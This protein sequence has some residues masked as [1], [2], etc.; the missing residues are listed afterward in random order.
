MNSSI[1]KIYND[2]QEKVINYSDTI[3]LADG[4]YVVSRGDGWILSR[5]NQILGGSVISNGST[6]IVG[7]LRVNDNA[8][9][10]YYPT[11]SFNEE[12]I[13]N[14]IQTV[15]AN[16]TEANQ[17]PIG[18][19]F[20]KTAPS[21]KNLY[22]YLQ[23]TY[24]R[25]EIIKVLQH[26]II[27][28]AVLY[29][30]SLGYVKSIEFNP[31]EKINKDFYFLTNDKCI[32]NEQFLYKKIL[33]TTKN[34]PTNNI[35]NSKVS[36]TQRVL[37][38]SNGLY[39][40]NKG[41]GYIRTNDKDLIGTLLIEAGSSGSI[42]QP[43]L[44]NTTRPLFTTSND[45]KFSQQYTEERLKDAFNVQL[46]NTSTSLFKF[47]EEAPSNKN[48]CIKAY[49]TYEKY[50]LIDYQN[51]S[52]VNKAEY[53]LPSL[54]YCEVTNAPSPESE[55]VKT[56]VAEDGFIQNGPE[57]EIVVGV[58]DPSENIQKINTAISDNYTY[59]IPGIVNNNPF[60][61]LFTVNTTGIYKIN[62]Q[63]NL[64]PLKIYEVIGSGNRNF[65]SGNLCDDDIKAINYITGFDSPN[66]KS[67][68]VVL[69]NKD[70]NYYIRVPQT[71]S[72]IE[73]QIQFK[74]EEGDLRNLMN[75]SVN[76]I[77]NLNSTGA[78]Y[79]TRQSPDVHDYISY[80]FTV[81]GNFNN[82]DTSNIRLYT[83]Y[84]QGI[85][86][87]FRVTETIDGY[88][89]INIQQNLN[90]LNSTQSIRLLNGAIY[91]LK[92][93]VTELNNYNI[94]LHIDITN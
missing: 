55:V 58:I 32:L 74:R 45:A 9:P 52:I 73:N 63:N 67:Y 91:I 51:G 11:P 53:Y 1:K 18:F 71:S 7:D 41:D 33:E 24:I 93:E 21:N 65:Q 10:Y 60:Y 22:M 4:N 25:Y 8:I 38:Y 3:D 61:I 26:E 29:V 19:E 14:N 23:Y 28:R 39:V 92:V 36:S 49:N 35:F 85:G 20:S 89:L 46:F 81:P 68:L 75:S 40:I 37:P 16:F 44:R 47:V 82:K 70:K 2:I 66:A 30:P 72:N 48:I 78:H 54:G 80:E 50:E 42:I 88:N 69:L 94:R 59:N 64:L 43:R 77:D 79:Y 83:S 6:G 76:I 84:N 87:L 31:G 13:K 17:I 12:Y 57:E 86:T 34:I 56:Q 5:Q 62:A 15:F 90:L 27:E